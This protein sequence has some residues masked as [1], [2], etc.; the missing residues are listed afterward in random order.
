MNDTTAREID[1]VVGAAAAASAVL[2]HTDEAT[3]AAWLRAL[4]AALDGQSGALV[5]A[6]DEET[7]LG[8]PRL[9]GELA[10]TTAQL[11]LFA[12]VI[13]EGSHLEATIDHPNPAATPPLPDLRRV[14]R[15]IGP[16]AVF[17]ASNFPFAFSIAGGDTASALAVGCPVVVKTHP[18]HPETSELTA[19]IVID[20]LREAGAPEGAFAV[21]SGFE[22]GLSLVDHPQLRAV[23]FTGSLRGGRALIDRIA[24]RPDP[25]PFYG[26]LGSLNPVVVTAAADA[27]HGTDLAAGLA[28]S[29]QLGAGQFCTK[30]GVVLIPQGSAL[31]RELPQHLSAQPR[32]LT[33][34]IAD[35]FA[36]GRERVRSVSGISVLPTTNG[37]EEE[38]S[39]IVA[40]VDVTTLEAHSQS[41]LEEVFGPFTLLVRYRDDAELDAALALLPG[42]LTATVHSARGEDITAI[43]HRLE[44][45]AGRLLF[46]GWPTGVAVSW[47]QQ[48]GGPW[49]STNTQFT[50]VGAAA[51][52]RFQRPVAYQN[53]PWAVLPMAL[54]DENPLRIPR[55]VDGALVTP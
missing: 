6:A 14:L 17:A 40:V 48:H 31:E 24:A 23:A 47:A 16:I 27:E 2:D 1:Q 8:A 12:D 51:V 29:F 28:A 42:S 7:A 52:R 45:L 13:E 43:I 49:P 26:E 38:T 39:P 55:R 37:A 34:A 5:S 32:M 35:G 33:P 25:I 53:A 46:G 10:R 44:P 4:A 50:S 19:R 11:R 20:A 18:G 9:S 21:V 30:P 3:R 41:L 36:T 54:R 15:P 22:A